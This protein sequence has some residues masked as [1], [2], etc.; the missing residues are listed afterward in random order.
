MGAQPTL[1]SRA[2][3]TVLVTVVALM[4]F[5]QCKPRF[6]NCDEDKQ[7]S[8]KESAGVCLNGKCVQCRDHG[9]C[10]A[11]NGY[12]CV[13]G[14]C[15]LATTV[16]YCDIQFPCLG[17]QTCYEHACISDPAPFKAVECSESSPK[18]AQGQLCQ[19]G[20]C[21]SP[22]NGGPGCDQFP[23]ALFDFESPTL[24]AD[25][26]ETL[27]RLAACLT[28]GAL[29]DKSLLLV[30]HTDNRGEFEFNF[31]LGAERAYAVKSFLVSMGVPANRMV[32]STRGKLDASGHDDQTAQLDR[33]VDIEVR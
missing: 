17:G 19:N 16:G 21:V 18:C 27:Q 2:L 12:A 13:A 24:R 33:K 28:T 22:P 14:T 7:C 11:S 29:R 6:P 9:N 10:Q 3:A 30:G 15:K 8:T 23:P 25:S 26:K 5:A 31:G 4:A 20:H 32:P 1:T